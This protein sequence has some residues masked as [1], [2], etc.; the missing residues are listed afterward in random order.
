M[1]RL[2]YWESESVDLDDSLLQRAIAEGRV[3]STCLFGGALVMEA[4]RTERDP[5]SVCPCPKREICKGRPQTEVFAASEASK[6]ISNSDASA[7]ALE[8][9]AHAR[10]LLRAMDAAIDRRK[11]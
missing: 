5:C 2:S 10:E 1:A 6:G 11:K 9:R 8:H 7:R 4:A 3:P